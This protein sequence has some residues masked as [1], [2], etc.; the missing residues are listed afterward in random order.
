MTY[1][2]HTRMVTIGARLAWWASMLVTLRTF[3][4]RAGADGDLVW[5]AY[6]SVD[7]LAAGAVSAIVSTV[8]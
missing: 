5:D 2:D 6:N 8:C 4:L 1:L 7:N 3:A